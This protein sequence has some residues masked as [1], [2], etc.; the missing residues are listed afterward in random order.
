MS[1]ES[2]RA[3]Q[4]QRIIDLTSSMLV[5]QERVAELEDKVDGLKYQLRRAGELLTTALNLDDTDP[6]WRTAVLAWGNATNEN[7]MP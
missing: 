4:G 2:T 3:K 1:L 5:A 7:R 6:D